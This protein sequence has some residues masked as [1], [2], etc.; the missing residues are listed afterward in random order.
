MKKFIITTTI[1]PPTE[2]IKQYDA[3]EDWQLIVTGDLKSPDE[4]PLNRGL[5][6]DWR[7]QQQNYRDLCG[8][9]GPNSTSRG[10]MI[11]VIEAWKLG[12]DIICTIDDDNFPYD[13]W[14]KN[15]YLGKKTLVD[16]R[17]EDLCYN[18]LGR[19]DPN[20]WHRGFPLELLPTNPCKP[21]QMEIEP[22]LQSNLWDGDPDVDAIVRLCLKPQMYFPRSITPF[23]GKRFMPI[24]SQNTM[25]L[26]KYA[27]DWGPFAFIGR[28]EDIWAGYVFQAMH[29]DSTV[30][31]EATVLHEQVRSM[32]SLYRD[33]EDE[34]YGHRHTHRFLF[35]I[36]KD[37]LKQAMRNHF[38]ALAL[39]AWDLYRS[40]FA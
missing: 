30:Y 40:H 25:F 24:N 31:G 34:L 12:A 39:E 14:G 15:I 6:F 13:N 4:Y 19:F 28:A 26:A 1:L 21:Y 17:G 8:L 37:G 9:I 22:A 23:C 3:M 7:Y 5:Y 29:P 33:L 36:E 10:R 18:P 27:M 16:V 32:D 38:P 20:K 2:A 11:A 35:D